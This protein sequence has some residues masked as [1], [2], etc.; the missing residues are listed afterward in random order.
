[1][2]NFLLIDDEPSLLRTYQRILAE[3]GHIVSVAG[4]LADARTALL[5]TAQ[6]GQALDGVLLDLTLE[7][8]DGAEL[9]P[10]VRQL[11]P[12]AQVAVVSGHV[13]AARVI[14][15]S[16]RCAMLVP[17]PLSRLAL[18][19]LAE[20]LKRRRAQ[21]P[22]LE[23][24]AARARLSPREVEVIEQSLAGYQNRDIAARLGCTPG[25]IR[26]YWNRIF[27]KTGCHSRWEVMALLG[28]RAPEEPATASR[29]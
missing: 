28:Q 5:E 7:D 14:T 2:A 6:S 16:S 9:L 21:A 17:K 8:G 26:T 19:A 25:C 12:L 22:T 18:L 20:E 13:D 1:M 11:H 23:D 3:A 24:L 29:G 10:V 4:G 15:L 27:R